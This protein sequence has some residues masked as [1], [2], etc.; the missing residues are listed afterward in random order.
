MIDHRIFPD[1]YEQPDGQE[2]SQPDNRAEIL[3]SLSQP[4]V[5]VPGSLTRDDDF[6]AF[7]QAERLASKEI[8]IQ[9]R[10]LPMLQGHLGDAK[11]V[12]GDVL[13]TN[14][15][16]LT[17]DSL[18]LAKPDRYEG[19]RPEQIGRRIRKELSGQMIPSFQDDLP[20][21]PNFFAEVKGQTG[22]LQVATRQLYYDMA[23]GARGIGAL[24]AYNSPGSDAILHNRAY[25][26]GCTYKDGQLIMYATHTIPSLKPGE[27]PG[28]VMTQLNAWA[29]TG[30]LGTFQEGIAA[31]RNGREWARKQREK[32]I[33]QANEQAFSKVK[34]GSWF[35]H[36]N[37]SL[38]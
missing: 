24:Q 4:R 16:P 22:S 3:H 29:M 20:A 9:S 2:L 8:Q 5:Y 12:N 35:C 30:N 28:Y 23:L 6:Q 25:T 21:L 33:E 1:G 32:V 18:V 34:V 17:D 7:K 15:D 26:I 36:P 37:V 14:L 13:F 10:I 19:A 11:Y 31:F 38:C 27:R